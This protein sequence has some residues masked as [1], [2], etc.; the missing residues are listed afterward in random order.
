MDFG[1]MRKKVEEN[2]YSS[3]GDFEKDFNLIWKNA[4]VYNEKDTIYYRAAV[5]I[6]EAGLKI[7]EDV[8]QKVES[9]RV[10]SRT[11]LH[12]PPVQEP[13]PLTPSTI[14]TMAIDLP[15]KKPLSC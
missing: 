8:R 10:D 15:G 2:E 13:P 9:A 11:G 5:R 7:L 12:D 4:T 14:A 1:T 6:K 3:L